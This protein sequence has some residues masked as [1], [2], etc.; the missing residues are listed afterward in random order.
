VHTLNKNL[1]LTAALH[2]LD[3]RRTIAWCHDLAWTNSQ[4]LPE[5]Y[6][7]YPWKLLRQKW[8]GTRYVT[9]SEPRK[10]EM[11]SLFGGNLPVEVVTGGVDIPAFLH[12]TPEMRAVE[13][14]HNLLD[15][16]LLLLLPARITRRKNIE[17]AL[18]VLSA[19]KNRGD[20]DCRLIVTGPPGPHNP[21][22]PGYL[23]ELLALRS[24]LQ[25]QDSAHFLYELSEPPFIPDDAT[26]ANLYGIAD[27]LFFPSLQEG[28]G[29]PILEAGL[30]NLPVFCSNLPPF[31]Q[32]GQ[33]NVHF[34]DPVADSA[35]LIAD[36]IHSH[37]KQD[38]QYRLKKRVRHE[39]RWDA[40]V[41]TRLVPLI[42]DAASVG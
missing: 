10:T 7:A 1:A 12:W 13:A 11:E 30:V 20:W 19:L 36:V 14:K 38:P 34:F 6:D 39:F 31:R 5:L 17:L 4:Y 26:V 3:G 18:H 2:R 42:E 27:A 37:F 15:A 22:N 29:L 35:D 21:T 24:G 8:P 28:F 32:T 33:D 25:L 9:V 23:G 41:R 40:I 16:D